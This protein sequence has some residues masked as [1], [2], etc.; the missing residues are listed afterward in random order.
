MVGYSFAG[1]QQHSI[2]S[3][4]FHFNQLIKQRQV[5]QPSSSLSIPIKT[6]WTEMEL[7]VKLMEWKVKAERSL[8]LITHN[9]E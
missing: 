8:R 4:S 9:N 5:N 6:N 3:L 1:Q 7:I 2:Q